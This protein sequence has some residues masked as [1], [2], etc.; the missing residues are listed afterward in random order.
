MGSTMKLK[1]PCNCMGQL[2]DSECLIV[3]GDCGIIWMVGFFSGGCTEISGRDSVVLHL[4][5]TVSII[6]EIFFLFKIITT[7]FEIF[8]RLNPGNSSVPREILKII[9]NLTT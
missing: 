5:V 4:G 8:S 2:R 6:K 7:V 1:S 9:Q 3:L